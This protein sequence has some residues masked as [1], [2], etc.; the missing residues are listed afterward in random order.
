MSCSINILNR[1]CDLEVNGE[2]VSKILKREKQK[3][4]EIKDI[5][6]LIIGE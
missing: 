1:E 4:I 2:F 3:P 5:N 6:D